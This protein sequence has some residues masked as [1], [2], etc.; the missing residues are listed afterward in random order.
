MESLDVEEKYVGLFDND[1]Q[2]NL[3][4]VEA[5]RERL[6][7]M[8]CKSYTEEFKTAMKILE[9]SGVPKLKNINHI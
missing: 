8:H 2:M 6:I 7:G 3:E 4:V 5:F 9:K 1:N